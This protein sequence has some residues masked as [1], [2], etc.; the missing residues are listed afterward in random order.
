MYLGKMLL[1]MKV[2]TKAYDRRIVATYLNHESVVPKLLR[3]PEH[4]ITDHLS[5]EQTLG[6]NNDQTA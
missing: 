3:A 5:A 1:N 4:K 2:G 6:T